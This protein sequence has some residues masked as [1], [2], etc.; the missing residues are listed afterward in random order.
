MQCRELILEDK[1]SDFER[2]ARLFL[3]HFIQRCLDYLPAKLDVIRHDPEGLYNFP[4]AMLDGAF[5]NRRGLSKFDTQMQRF[6]KGAKTLRLEVRLKTGRVRGYYTSGGQPEIT[7]FISPENYAKF[8]AA[9]D[10]HRHLYYLLQE[11]FANSRDTL[12]HELQHAYDDWASQGKYRDNAKTQA[13]QTAR[14][15]PPEVFG[16]TLYLQDPIEISARYRQ[17]VY[18][19]GA[20]GSITWNEYLTKFRWN[21]EGWRLIAPEEQKRLIGRL[22]AYWMSQRPAQQRDIAADFTLFKTH[23]KARFPGLYVSYS[24]DSGAISIDDFG[25]TDKATR[26]LILGAIVRFADIRGKIVAVAGLPLSPATKAMGFV[27]QKSRN[28][29][30]ALSW[31]TTI[32]RPAR[33]RRPMQQAA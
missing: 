24:A 7:L 33:V 1:Q 27:S 3:G 31:D 2:L 18:N 20:V 29:N 22:A 30:Y 4:G 13:A 16:Q 12:I 14:R 19:L 5:P 15:S 28:R 10:E 8:Q 23:L 26:D 21:F 6:I 32:Y 9:L 25:T 11:L 17:T